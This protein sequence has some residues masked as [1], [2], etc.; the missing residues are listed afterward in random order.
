MTTVAHEQRW[1]TNLV[2]CSLGSFTTIVGMTLILPILP[3]YVQDLGV[4]DPGRVAFWSG[5]TY[6]ATFASA[7]VTAPLW[8]HLGDRFGRKP[9]LLRAALGMAV[10]TSLIG[11]AHNVWQLFA[12]RL[13]VGLLGG[14][15]SGSTILVA[16]QTPREHS[17]TALGVLSAAIMAGTVVGPLIG[18]TLTQVYAFEVAFLA[19]AALIFVAFVGTL[20]FLREDRTPRPQPASTEPRHGWSAVPRR[21]LVVT[22]LAL[23][24]LLTFATFSVEPVITVFVRELDGASGNLPIRAAIVFSLTAFGTIVSAPLLGRLADR[25]GHLRVLGASLAAASALLAAQSLATSLPLFAGLRFGTGLALGGIAPTVVATIRALLPEGTVGLVLGYNV[26][27]QYLGQV[28]GPISAGLL[29]GW[30]GPRWVFVA[31]AAVTAVGVL[32]VRLVHR[33]PALPSGRGRGGDAPAP[34]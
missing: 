21:P 33:R 7:A 15:A 5:L 12:L 25:I 30:T 17:A 9:M 20:L 27:A 28:L 18:A 14:F 10:A 11:L 31:T 34:S 29:A 24:G 23:S 8:G 1:R 13:L 2:V 16:A 19:T 3:L 6:A 26:S 22:L 4:T 32:A